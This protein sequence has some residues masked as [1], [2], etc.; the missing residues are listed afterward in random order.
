ME[1]AYTAG[2]RKI[3]A[4]GHDPSFFESE[5]RKAGPIDIIGGFPENYFF[6]ELFVAIPEYARSLLQSLIIGLLHL[7]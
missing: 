5:I 2:C 3:A 1:D 7:A 6:G 4:L